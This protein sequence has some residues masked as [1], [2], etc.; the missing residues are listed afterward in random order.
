[1]AL[2]WKFDSINSLGAGFSLYAYYKSNAQAR[3]RIV[4]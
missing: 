4:C 1:M 2:L 3:L